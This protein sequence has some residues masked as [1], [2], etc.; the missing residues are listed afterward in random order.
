MKLTFPFDLCLGGVST[1]NSATV[2]RRWASRMIYFQVLKTV[3][4]RYVHSLAITHSAMVSISACASR[5][6]S[7]TQVLHIC[8]RGVCWTCGESNEL[9]CKGCQGIYLH[10]TH[11]SWEL[12][13]HP[14][15][16]L[17]H[18]GVLPWWP[19]WQ[20]GEWWGGSRQHQPA[21]CQSHWSALK[22]C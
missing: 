10:C 19:P 18:Q 7:K 12:F 1:P 14:C 11:R 4:R 6:H 17:I 16:K 5:Q 13:G 21:L 20:S 22:R 9:V 15:P 3:I 2:T 8:I